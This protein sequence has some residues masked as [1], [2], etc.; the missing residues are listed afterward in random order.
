MSTTTRKQSVPSVPSSP[1]TVDEFARTPEYDDNRV[2]LIDGYIVRRDEM[3]PAH[4]GATE[5]LRRRFEAMVPA[6]WCVREDKPVRIPEWTEPLPDIAIVRM[7][8]HDL[9]RPPP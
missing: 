2:E 6:A 3:K 7:H 9:P 8:L 5:C 4:V 1:M